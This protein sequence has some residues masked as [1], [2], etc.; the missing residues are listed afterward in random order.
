MLN[1]LAAF[2]Q[3]ATNRARHSYQLKMQLPGYY[4]YWE[5][6]HQAAG[7][8]ELAPVHWAPGNA[9]LAFANRAAGAGELVQRVAGTLGQA[10]AEQVKTRRHFHAFAPD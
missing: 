4:S 3:G 9:G 6:A 1:L 2:Q 8:W 5:S 7:N 10:R